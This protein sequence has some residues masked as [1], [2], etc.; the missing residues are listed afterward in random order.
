MG[1]FGVSNASSGE[2]AFI[3]SAPGATM[4]ARLA[5]FYRALWRRGEAGITVK[6][7]LIREGEER[8]IEN[9]DDGR[10][11]PVSEARRELLSARDQILL[12]DNRRWVWQALAS[13]APARRGPVA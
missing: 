12:G 9:Q 6:L 10:S 8:E 13:A 1:S 2:S 4:L 3:S 7:A 11:I 5:D